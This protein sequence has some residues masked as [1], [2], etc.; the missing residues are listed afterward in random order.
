MREVITLV[1]DFGSKDEYAGVM[2][3]VILSRNPSAKIV[4]ITHEIERFNIGQ[5]AMII[6]RAHRHF[7]EGAVHLAVV[8]PGVGGRRKEII[9]EAGGYFFVGPDN[10][11]FSFILKN[12][13]NK[14]VYHIKRESL[15]CEEI[16][17]T[18][19]GRDIFAP[20]AALLSRGFSPS[21]L[22]SPADE[23]V[24]LE[25][26][27]PVEVKGGIKG[28]LLYFDRFGNGVTTIPNHLVD[29]EWV[30]EIKGRKL[31][32][33][34]HYEEGKGI[35][36]VKGSGG[37]VEISSYMKDLRRITRIKEGCEVLCLRRGK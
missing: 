8:D 13:E 12:Y 33:F 19:H 27:F 32:F 6:E 22:G 25:D 3:G 18:F 37:F 1:T 10:G 24:I 35:F 15:G 31:P 2:K 5:A 30:L 26:L 21:E 4:D 36:A 20:V 17:S 29:D 16:S 14:K 23:F 11:I 7:P 28:K 34:S 9:V